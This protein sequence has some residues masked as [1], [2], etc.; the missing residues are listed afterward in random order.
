MLTVQSDNCNLQFSVNGRY[1]IK[2][3]PEVFGEEQSDS[4]VPIAS[5]NLLEQNIERTQRELNLFRRVDA[6]AR[7][8]G[9]PFDVT[10]KEYEEK[11][12]VVQKAWRESKQKSEKSSAPD[13]TLKVYKE[14]IATIQEAWR[15][16]RR[17]SILGPVLGTT[18]P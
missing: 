11:I 17:S 3:P 1:V 18:S 8:P 5:Q 16:R 15:E 13:V 2:S 6:W 10:S 7:T 9:P 4:D 14:R 12:T